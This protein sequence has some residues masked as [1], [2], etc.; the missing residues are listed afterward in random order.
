MAGVQGLYCC[1]PAARCKQGSCS[2][3]RP[4]GGQSSSC[5]W[6]SQAC[7]TCLAL[8]V[9]PARHFSSFWLTASSQSVQYA[10]TQGWQM[11]WLA[12]M[13]LEA[14]RGSCTKWAAHRG[15]SADKVCELAGS[16]KRAAPTQSKPQRHRPVPVGVS[17]LWWPQPWLGALVS[18]MHCSGTACAQCRWRQ[19]AP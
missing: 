19:G 12:K 3:C 16:A 1:S 18:Q 8:S 13:A 11:P 5:L 9:L 2:C 10:C 6:H 14:G 17:H 7:G 4:A 15:K